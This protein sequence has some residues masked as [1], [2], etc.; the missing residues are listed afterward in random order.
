MH[1][2]EMLVGQ[3]E[4]LVW[5]TV[6]ILT[7]LLTICCCYSKYCTRRRIEQ[8]RAALIRRWEQEEDQPRFRRL[9]EIRQ[10]LLYLLFY[11]EGPQAAATSIPTADPA[12]DDNHSPATGPLAGIPLVF[13]TAAVLHP[14]TATSGGSDADEATPHRSRQTSHAE[15]DSVFLYGTTEYL[16]RPPPPP[17]R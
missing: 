12:V 7:L 15:E 3:L 16:Q 8:R 2:P 13:V 11:S 1:G 4:G 10:G 14:S 5:S 17:H 6:V 9:G